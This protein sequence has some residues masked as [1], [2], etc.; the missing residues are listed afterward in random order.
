ME[1]TASQSIH[2]H[3]W[4]SMAKVVATNDVMNTLI[5]LFGVYGQCAIVTIYWVSSSLHILF[6]TLDVT[7]SPKFE[8]S[9]KDSILTLLCIAPHRGSNPQSLGCEPNTLHL[10]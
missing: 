4:Q 8:R 6:H 7:A 1:I 2:Y 10:C 5:D 3:M 9:H